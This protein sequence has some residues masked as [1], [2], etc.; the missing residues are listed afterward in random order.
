M[1]YFLEGGE[2]R[3]HMEYGIYEIV[4]AALGVVVACL[5]IRLSKQI[6]M[7]NLSRE[8]GYF[9][10]EDTNIRKVE[11]ADYKRCIGLFDLSDTLHFKLYGNGDAVLLKE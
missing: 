4:I 3:N 9:V 6:N 5:Q 7:Q 1:L 2:G 10:I 8:K 11:D